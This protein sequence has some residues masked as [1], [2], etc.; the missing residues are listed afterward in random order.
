MNWTKHPQID[1]K[2]LHIGCPHCST[3]DLEAPMDLLIGVGFG[4]SYVTRDGDEIRDCEEDD[5]RVSE[6]EAM[7][8]ADPDHDWRIHR[9]GPLHEEVFQ[10]HGPRKWVCIESGMGFA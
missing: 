6:I 10:R 3:A 8:A 1:P 2:D 7:A 5:A 9:H 4:C